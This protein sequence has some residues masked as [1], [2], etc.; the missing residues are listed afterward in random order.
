MNIFRSG[1]LYWW[2]YLE[3]TTDL[4]KVADNTDQNME[5]VL[6]SRNYSFFASNWF[7]PVFCG[8]VLLIIYVFSVVFFVV[9]FFLFA[10][11]NFFLE[12]NELCGKMPKNKFSIS[13]KNFGKIWIF[14]VQE[15]SWFTHPGE[16]AEHHISKELN[17]Q[18][19]KVI[20]VVNNVNFS[21]WSKW[22]G[23]YKYILTNEDNFVK[24]YTQTMSLLIFFHFRSQRPWGGLICGQQFYRIFM[25]IS[26]NHWLTYICGR[27]SINSCQ[28]ECVTIDHMDFTSISNSEIL[29]GKLYHR[30]LFID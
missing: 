4:L 5:S 8:F 29:F 27:R 16:K 25:I 11:A 14:S 22:L 23:R 26:N 28:L 6:K 9:V 2:R 12:K 17:G 19:L 18:S 15:K 13:M 7:S 24:F 1:Q 30:Y 3:I 20:Y 21:W 10:M